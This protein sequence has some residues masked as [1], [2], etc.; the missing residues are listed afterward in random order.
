MRLPQ[1]FILF[2]LIFSSQVVFAVSTSPVLTSCNITTTLRVVS[3][4]AEVEC[5]QK[6]IGVVADG[7]F[8]PLTKAAVMAFQSSKG[9]VADGIV[10]ILTRAA[11]NGVVTNNIVKN[12]ENVDKIQP[13]TPKINSNL[14]NLDKFIAKV[15]EINRKNGSS[16]KDLQLMADTLRETIINSD[17][18]YKK[19]FEELLTNESKLSIF[20]K[21][22]S[23][24][25]F[26]KALSKTLS[27]LGITPSMAQA[28]AGIPF[29]GALLYAFFCPYNASWMITI[30][31]LPPTFVA[32]LTYYPGT[33]GFASYNIPFT[34]WLLGSYVTSG[35]CM[36]PGK[37]VV[38]I[39][40]E[41]TITPM[42]GS[43]PI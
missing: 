42:V 38:V 23:L 34:S 31:P 5:L 29:G 33:Q 10:G 41:G 7:R 28:S 1:L 11:L 13:P 24:S 39:P 37:P 21:K 30:E 17:I 14:A 6:K 26:D 27:F 20:S 25:I 18:D 3:K 40:T 9:L 2:V 43:S 32:L 22:P 36:I 12:S 4:G 16:E 19:E 8:G 35:I 15:V